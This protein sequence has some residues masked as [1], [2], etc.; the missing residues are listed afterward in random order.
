[1]HPLLPVLPLLSSVLGLWFAAAPTL[2]SQCTNQWLPGPPVPG[3]GGQVRC[4]ANWDPDGAGPA[5]ARLV[6]GG[7]FAAA[8]NV[9]VRNLATFEP[10]SGTWGTVGGGLDGYVVELLARPNGELLAAGSFLLPGASATVGVVRWS[11][12]AWT[13][14][15]SG[16]DWVN[17]LQALPNGDL[18]AG[19]STGVHRWNGSTWVPVGSGLTAVAAIVALPNGDLVAGWT[20]GPQIGFHRW[21][22]IQWS[23]LG[24]SI[25]TAGWAGVT[26]LAVLPNGDLIASTSG[27]QT[28]GGGGVLRWNGM[29]WQPMHGTANVELVQDLLVL[30]NGTLVAAGEFVIGGTVYAPVAQWTGTDWQGLGSFGGWPAALCENPGGGIAVGGYLW[31]AQGG[32]PATGAAFWNGTT[33]SP[34]AQGLSW[35]EAVVELPGGDVVLGGFFTN[36]CGVGANH[37]VRW[38]GS[39]WHPLGSGLDGRVTGLVVHPNGD[40]IVAGNFTTAGGG[41]AMHVARWDGSTWHP[42]AGG[43]GGFVTKLAIG[44][45]GDLFAILV[46]PGSAQWVERWDGAAWHVLGGITAVNDLAVMPDG[47]VVAVGQFPGLV[48]RWNGAAWIPLSTGSFDPIGSHPSRVTVLPNGDLVVAGLQT[49]PGTGHY[50]W[51]WNGTNWLQLPAPFGLWNAALATMLALP[52]GDLIAGS[53]YGQLR[54]WNGSIWSPV[55]EVDGVLDL[56]LA[57][58]GDVLAAGQFS[59]IGDHVSSGLARLTTTCPAAAIASGIGCTGA[60]GGTLGAT[61][62]PW[63]GS[64]YRATATGLPANALAL[65]LYGFTPTAVALPSLLPEGLAGCTLLVAPDLFDLHLTGT[66]SVHTMVDLPNA[67]ALVATTFHQQVLSITLDPQF[68]ITAV[69]ATNRLVLVTGSF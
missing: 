49:T 31:H 22:G 12:G 20:V 24:A 62:L 35:A 18:V 3:I 47:E 61:S 10:G 30:A 40:L 38:D 15:G 19:S 59:S 29:S 64:I 32:T 42:L 21:D 13:S 54:R 45:N 5:P 1:M 58:N 41:S 34:L 28:Q 6:F 53:E 11:G 43:L 65:N 50:P 51:R 63:I 4:C 69:A 25:F 57:R 68:V 7:Q 14:V 17:C 48:V 36:A 8:G 39:G 23:A 55:V 33:W 37:I 16:P 2:R 46:I 27:A 66:G 26:D 56:A 67:P 52:N 9:V 44:P 60:T